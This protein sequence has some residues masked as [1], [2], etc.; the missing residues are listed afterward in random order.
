MLLRRSVGHFKLLRCNGGLRVVSCALVDR[1]LKQDYAWGVNL[2]LP[3]LLPGYYASF[4]GVV[5][6]GPRR[7]FGLHG[8]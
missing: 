2:W 7:L 8:G 6:Q 3:V 1:I 5:E 4:L